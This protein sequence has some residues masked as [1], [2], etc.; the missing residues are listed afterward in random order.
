MF[1]AP[2]FLHER[3]AW[4]RPVGSPDWRIQQLCQPQHGLL[5][6]ADMEEFECYSVI[7]DL[8]FEWQNQQPSQIFPNSFMIAV[9]SKIS[10]IFGQCTFGRLTRTSR[11]YSLYIFCRRKPVVIIRWQWDSCASLLSISL[12]HVHVFSHLCMLLAGCTTSANLWGFSHQPILPG[13]LRV[14]GAADGC[15]Q[16]ARDHALLKTSDPVAAL[17]R[18]EWNLDI[19]LIIIL[20]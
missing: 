14:H 17:K 7:T 1:S 11:S 15:W 16:T 13:V 5:L 12:R 9:G 19:L 20:I 10:E 6:A 18:F 2:T 8:H 4:T 3:A